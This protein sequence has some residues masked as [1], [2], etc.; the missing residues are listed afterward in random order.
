MDDYCQRILL[1]M[2]ESSDLYPSMRFNELHK[3]MNKMGFELSKP[4][5]LDHLKHLTE[6]KF[7]VRKEEGVQH[8]TY[9][10]DKR[11]I[12]NA[13]KY[14]DQTKAIQRDAEKDREYLFSLDVKDQIRF[15][16]GIV[17]LRKLCGIQAMVDFKLDPENIG[18]FFSFLFWN[19]PVPQY[20]EH[21]MIEKCL[22]DEE[23]RKQVFK[24]IDEWI[25]K[26]TE[27][28]QV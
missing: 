9:R 8:V 26:G 10:L 18:K 3:R 13:K 1:V 28:G 14:V 25:G 27:T 23:Y 4:S 19:S 17:G 21:W 15:V 7:L 5:L 12:G 11:K 2:V 22:A 6:L 20:H 24:A 16:A